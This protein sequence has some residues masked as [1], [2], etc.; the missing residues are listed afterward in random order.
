MPLQY[1]ELV[2][3]AALTKN[4]IRRVSA[5]PEVAQMWSINLHAEV[6]PASNPWHLKAVHSYVFFFF[7]SLTQS[8]LHLR[9]TSCITYRSALQLQWPPLRISL[10]S[11][12]HH[13]PSLSSLSQRIPA[14]L[15]LTCYLFLHRVRFLFSQPGRSLWWTMIW[16]LFLHSYTRATWVFAVKRYQVIEYITFFSFYNF[17]SAVCHQHMFMH[18]I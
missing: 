11:N 7:L 3:T 16:V 10:R 17:L 5:G 15:H 2:M 9:L 18:I 14:H 8:S 12:L 6:N 4:W 1:S 13:S